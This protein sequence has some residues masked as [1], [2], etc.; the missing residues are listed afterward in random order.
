VQASL[1]GGFDDGHGEWVLGGAFDA[2][3][4]AQQLVVITVAAGGDDAG[5]GGSSFGECAGLVNDQGV[6]LLHA[7]EGFGVLYQDAQ[8]CAATDTDHDRH[9]GGQPERAGAGDDQDRHGGD[10][11]VGELRVRAGMYVVKLGWGA[12]G[13]PEGLYSTQET[14]FGIHGGD[15]ETSLL[16]AFRPETVDMTAAQ[17]FRSSAE[18]SAISPIGGISAAWIASDLNP[19]GVVGE[20]HLATAE[21]GHATA[22]KMVADVIGLLR[23]VANQSLE[24]ISPV[25]PAF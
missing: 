1:G 24:G 10:E 16:L 8:A 21:K 17:D 6:D 15:V 4:D 12:H 9:G 22:E 13:L 3:G 7:F 11:G 2:G 20:A 14:T 5:D 25:T 23:K 18:T 19:A